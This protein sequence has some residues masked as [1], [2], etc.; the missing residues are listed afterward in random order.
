MSK[1]I[2]PPHVPAPAIRADGLMNWRDIGGV[3][4]GLSTE[5]IKHG[6]AYRSDSLG[7]LSP[8]AVE[9]LRSRGIGLVIDLRSEH[10]VEQHGRLSDPSITWLHLPMG[11]PSWF[12]DKVLTEEDPMAELYRSMTTQ[13]APTLVKVLDTVAST[14][15]PLVIHCTSGKDRTGVAA[16]L[17]QTALG[18]DDEVIAAEYLASAENLVHHAEAM[19]A[20]YPDM[21][22]AIPEQLQARFGGVERQWL[23]AALEPVREA[24]GID[25]WLT[26]HGSGATTIDRLHSRFLQ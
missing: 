12:S 19:R 11:G 14:E 3:D 13:M 6:L 1:E 17:L 24:G 8:R 7:N 21:A 22:A 5:P 15:I 25:G 20:R 23:D 9:Q 16:A 4:T 26:N 10:E 18:V 2:S